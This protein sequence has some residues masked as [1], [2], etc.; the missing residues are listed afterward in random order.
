[1]VSN[2][3]K[4]T[5]YFKHEC[6]FKEEIMMNKKQKLANPLQRVR[7]QQ[8][9]IKSTVILGKCPLA[10]HFYINYHLVSFDLYAKSTRRYFKKQPVYR[11]EV[12]EMRRL[13]YFF[14]IF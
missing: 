8:D 14:E 2:R 10:H 1:M 11:C 3:A 9:S 5:I 4:H 13:Y 6:P 7:K 12:Q